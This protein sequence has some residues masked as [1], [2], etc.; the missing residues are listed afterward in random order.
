M[1]WQLSL[2]EASVLTTDADRMENVCVME[3]ATEAM[4]S[5]THLC[6]HPHNMQKSRHCIMLKKDPLVNWMVIC[7]EV[8]H[9]PP[10]VQ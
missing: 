1:K 10:R 8:H 3:Q 6:R 7:K 5:D 2:E 4:S 9:Q